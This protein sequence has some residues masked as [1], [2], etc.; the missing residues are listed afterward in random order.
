MHNKNKLT[1]RQVGD[2]R[3]PNLNF[4]S[5]EAN[6]HDWMNAFYCLLSLS[7][8]SSSVS[9]P[10]AL[11]IFS[12]V[13]QHDASATIKNGNRAMNGTLYGNRKAISVTQRMTESK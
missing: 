12:A 5:E 4:P 10:N 7:A 11:L 8:S 3:I 13:P 1:Y 2:Y 6:I 9:I